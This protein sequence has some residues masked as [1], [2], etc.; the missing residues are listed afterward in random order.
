MNDKP[1]SPQPDEQAPNLPE[2]TLAYPEHQREF[3]AEWGRDE[4]KDPLAKEF[5]Q[6]VLDWGATCWK[7]KIMMKVTWEW[8]LEDFPSSHELRRRFVEPFL[9]RQQIDLNSE[10]KEA[11]E[12]REA[13]GRTKSKEWM[14]AYPQE[15]QLFLS[16][17]GIDET[18]WDGAAYFNS[19]ILRAAA[20]SHNGRTFA[21]GYIIL[22]DYYW[23]EFRP[24]NPSAREVK[25]NMAKVDEADGNQE[26]DAA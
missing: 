23:R 6:E 12:W 13:E 18:V 4:S 9:E 8:L 25:L 20:F 21:Q 19:A 26:K 2:W 16:V 1:E 15:A 17:F 3:L 22:W 24:K 11:E 14:K 10:L 5:N 7:S